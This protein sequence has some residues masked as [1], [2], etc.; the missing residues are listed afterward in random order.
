M[1]IVAVGSTVTTAVGFCNWLRKKGKKNGILEI[2]TWKADK[3]GIYRW[4]NC[5]MNYYGFWCWAWKWRCPNC[6]YCSDC[7]VRSWL[8]VKRAND[9]ANGGGDCRDVQTI[10]RCV[11]DLPLYQCLND[12]C[13]FGCYCCCCCYWRWSG[14]GHLYKRGYHRRV[15]QIRHRA[16]VGAGTRRTGNTRCGRSCSWRASQSRNGWNPTR[17]CRTWRQIA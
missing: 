5:E 14:R 6:C 10:R 16:P 13:Y 11:I 8:Q 17:T 12:C 2:W 15:G 9:D 1:G 7:G 4:D 3:V